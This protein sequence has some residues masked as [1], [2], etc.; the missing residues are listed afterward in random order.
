[1]GHVTL[2]KLHSQYAKAC[3]T[4]RKFQEA[5]EAYE[6]AHDM[7]SVVR[8]CLE[9]LNDPEK[10]FSIVRRTASATGAL[11]AL[12]EGSRPLEQVAQYCQGIGDFRGAI[13]FLL[14]AQRSEESFNISKAQNQV[15][16]YTT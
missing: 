4:E 6:K 9:K 5:A 8:V 16:T 3:E 10:A 1:M 11:M 7:D 14:M 2:P 12:I 13:E 15:E